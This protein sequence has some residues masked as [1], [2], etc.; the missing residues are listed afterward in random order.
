MKRIL[1]QAAGRPGHIFNLGQGILPNTPEGN[2]IAMVEYVHELSQRVQE[3][4]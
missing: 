1:E 2:A 3:L 4:A